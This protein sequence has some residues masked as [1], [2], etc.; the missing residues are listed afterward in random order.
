MGVAVKTRGGEFVLLT[1]NQIGAVLMDYLLFR[2]TQL[3]TLPANAAVV[4]TI[5]TTG[6][7]DKIAKN[8]N[9]EIFSVLTGFKFIGEK[10]KEWE[11][12]NKHTFIFG[13]EESFGYLAGT[14]ARDKDAVVA[15]MLLAEAACYFKTKGE[16]VFE[17]LNALYEKYGYYAEASKSFEFKS[18]FPMQE[19]AKV[20][21]GLRKTAVTSLA[22]IRVIKTSDYALGVDGL[23]KTNAVKYFLEDGS[24]L[25]VRPSGTEPKLKI[26][27]SA[28]AKTAQEAKALNERYV[29][30]LRGRVFGG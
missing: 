28:T 16:T 18:I 25:A 21:E 13:Y 15:S 24:W 20:M 12:N 6:L 7:A 14:H 27:A 17:H 10:I 3:K 22:G 8:Y 1:G 19:M 9:T 11:Q 5:V 23:P 29:G 30:D 26:Y 4:K 2:K